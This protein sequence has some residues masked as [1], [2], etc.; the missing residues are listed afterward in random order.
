[1]ASPKNI[2]LTGACGFVG[3]TIAEHIHRNTNWNIIIIDKLSYA[4][5][6]L[7]RLTDSGLYYSPRVKLL[8]FDLSL[9]LSDGIVY[10]LGKDINYIIH[11]GADTH[12]DNSILYPREFILNNV[13]STITI[14]DYAR[15]HC[16]NLEKI[17]LFSTDEVFGNAPNGISYKENDR[18]APSNPYSAS[19]SACEKISMSYYTT[20]NIPLIIIHVMNVFG[21]RQLVEKF[22]PKCIKKILNNEIIQIHTDKTKTII[23]SRYYIHARNVASAIMFLLKNSKIG[24]TYNIS[25]QKEMSNLEM[26][27]FIAKV[28]NKKLE[29][30]LVSL[31][32]ERPNDSLDIQ[33]RLSQQNILDLGWE[34]PVDFEKSLEKTIKWTVNNPK[35]LE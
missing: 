18:H 9:P 22:I 1:M 11:L 35:W 28:L 13:S 21:E 20:Y 34:I 4:S 24:E 2:I 19:K 16:P 15:K 12:V 25:G 6:G 29:Y 23:G 32:E 17:F 7:D 26:A 10:Y 5:K 31:P 27:N 8:T 30:V 33:Y 3:S 14:L